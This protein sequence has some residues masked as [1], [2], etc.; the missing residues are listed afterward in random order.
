MRKTMQPQHVVEASKDFLYNGQKVYKGTQFLVNWLE[1]KRIE[2][3]GLATRLE[4]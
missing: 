1:R 2:K 3:E 4:E